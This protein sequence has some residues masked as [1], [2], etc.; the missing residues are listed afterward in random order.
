MPIIRAQICLAAGDDADLQRVIE[1]SGDLLRQAGAARQVQVQ[2]EVGVLLAR[3]LWRRGSRQRALDA[4]EEAL[5]LAA[6]RGHIRRFTEGGADVGTMLYELARLDRHAEAAR[7]M[8]AQVTHAAE[9][10]RPA[11]SLIDPLTER[12]LEILE[13]LAEGLTN[14]EVGARLDISPFT[15]RNHTTHIYA[16]LG[17]NHRDDAIAAARALRLIRAETSGLAGL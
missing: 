5:A 7:E 3:M 14:K 17:V 10:R 9:A 11:P 12:E 2:I 6:P 8:L 4:L 13:L 15:V 1:E 16:K